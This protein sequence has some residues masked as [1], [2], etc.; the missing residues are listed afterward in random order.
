MDKPKIY[1]ETTMF[2]FYHEA[3]DYGNYPKH[4]AQVREVFGR[5]KAGMYEPH[6]SILAIQELTKNL[7]QIKRERMTALVAEFGIKVLDESEEATRI[8]A[9][10]VQEAAVPPSHEADAAHIAIA[11]VN[12]LDF[13]VSLNFKHI[14]RLWTIERVR[15]VNKREGY[16][17]V[18]IYKPSEALKL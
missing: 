12:G 3:R 2:S 6:T 4:K 11:T 7:D 1:L 18:G 15:R 16:Q 10:Y 8:S 14:A 5:I 9:L 17:D 13:I